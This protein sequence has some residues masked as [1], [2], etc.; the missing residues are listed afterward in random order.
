MSADGTVP[1]N[2]SPVSGARPPL[3]PP[4]PLTEAQFA[5]VREAALAFKSV[6]RAT[7][8]ALSSSLVTL[9][10]ALAA[11]PFDLIWPSS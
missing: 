9:F 7:R 8:V 4:S 5:V 11:V 10:I 3:A 6:K 2:P 1:R